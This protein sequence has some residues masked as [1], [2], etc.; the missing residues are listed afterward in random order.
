M[1]YGRDYTPI[2]PAQVETPLAGVN[3]FIS[4]FDGLLYGKFPSGDVLPLVPGTMTPL[5]AQATNEGDANDLVFTIDGYAAYA[6]GDILYLRVTEANTQSVT[7]DINGLGAQAVKYLGNLDLEIPAG[8]LM[9]GST[10]AFIYNNGRFE[11]LGM[12]VG[13]EVVLEAVVTFAQLQVLAPGSAQARWDFLTL[14]PK[15]N[16]RAMTMAATVDFAG[17]AASAVDAT[18]TEIA[19]TADVFGG[20]VNLFTGAVAASEGG[21]MNGLQIAGVIPS[22]VDLQA[23]RADIDVTGDDWDNITSGAFE[24]QIHWEYLPW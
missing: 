17:G 14:P 5:A 10:N 21:L 15:S 13:N 23:Y 24:V 19:S 8:D 16:L 4:I 18:V 11:F 9:A 1:R 22:Q 7:I 2:D 12:V 6:Q 20:T 3:T